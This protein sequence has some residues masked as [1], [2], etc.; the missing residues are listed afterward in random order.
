MIHPSKLKVRTSLASHFTKMAA[1]RRIFVFTITSARCAPVVVTF[2]IAMLIHVVP[3]RDESFE[4]NRTN[5]VGTIY[6][7]SQAII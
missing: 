1:H 4:M 3:V 2:V 7:Y 6:P 5:Q